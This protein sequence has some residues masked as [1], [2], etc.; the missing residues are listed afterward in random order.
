MTMSIINS[1]SLLQLVISPK[2]SNADFCTLFCAL[3]ATGKEF[4]RF[5]LKR[6]KYVKTNKSQNECIVRIKCTDISQ[7]RLRFGFSLLYKTVFHLNSLTAQLSYEG[8][9]AVEGAK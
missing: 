9:A 1:P 4:M 3:P 7:Y 2:T 5:W 8:R 6:T